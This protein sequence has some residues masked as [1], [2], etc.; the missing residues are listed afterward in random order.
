MSNTASH[1]GGDRS[2]GTSGHDNHHGQP[3]S[4]ACIDAHAA[5]YASHQQQAMPPTNDSDT[6]TI[7]T[8]TIDSP[9]G[10]DRYVQ[11]LLALPH[12][13]LKKTIRQYVERETVKATQTEAQQHEFKTAKA[14]LQREL[15]QTK[16][17]LEYMEEY[18]GI[19]Y[20]DIQYG[21]ASTTAVRDQDYNGG[22]EE[23]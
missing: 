18:A 8:Y 14:A 12:D 1:S 13:Q 21:M 4:E 5:E 10:V 16:A 11:S 15:K 9:A 19:T 20:T 23:E 6:Y 17:A 22:G 2:K 3:V 7:D